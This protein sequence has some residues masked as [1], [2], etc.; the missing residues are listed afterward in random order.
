MYIRRRQDGFLK[1]RK[2]KRETENVLSTE[3][4]LVAF[5]GGRAWRAFPH[6]STSCLYLAVASPRGQF[7]AHFPH[8]LCIWS[9]P[10]PLHP[11]SLSLRYRVLLWGNARPPPVS[12]VIGSH[13]GRGFCVQS[14][15]SAN[16]LHNM[17]QRGGGRGPGGGVCDLLFYFENGPWLHVHVLVH[18]HIS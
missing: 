17:K 5:W 7:S 13:R 3:R 2:Q 9:P 6:C 16:C 1:C 4:R 8:L 10:T 12:L 11:L 15:G 14:L 18:V